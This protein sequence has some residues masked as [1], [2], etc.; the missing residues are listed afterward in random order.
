MKKVFAT[1]LA[2]C[3]VCLAYGAKPEKMSAVLTVLSK[4][5]VI[6]GRISGAEWKNAVQIYGLVKHNSAAMTSRQGT[7]YFGVDKKYFNFAAVTELPPGNIKLLDRVKKRDG[8]VYLDDNVEITI[9]PPHKKFVYQLIVNPQGTLFDRKF[10]VTYGSTTHTD[11]AD[12]TPAA[13]VKSSFANG[14]WTLEGRIPLADMEVSALKSGEVWGILAGRSWQNPGEQTTLKKSM[15]FTNSDE[16]AQFT[17][18]A[19]LP[20]VSFAGLGKNAAKGDFNIVFPVSNPSSVAREVACQVSIVSDSAPRFLDTVITVPAGKTLPAVLN[21]SESNIVVRSISALFK[22]VKSGKVIFERTFTYDP[23][24]KS[25]WNDPAQKRSA[26]LEIG[27]YPYYG[28]IRAR[29]GN[30]AEKISGWQEGTLRLESKEGK[31]VARQNAVKTPYGFE[32]VFNLKPAP[33][34][35][36]IVLTLSD[37]NGKKAEKKRSFVIEKFPWEHNDIGKERIIIPPF[38]A[39]TTPGERSASAT[40]TAYRFGSGF[41]DRVSADGVENIL[42]APVTLSINGKVLTEESFRFTEKSPD[43]VKTDSLLKWEGGSVRILGTMDYDGFYRFSMNVAPDKAQQINSAVLTIPLKREFAAQLHSVCNQM[44]YNDAIYLPKTNGV[45]WQ[46]SQTRRT[47]QLSGN[48]MPYVWVGNLSRGIAWMAQS[49]LNWSLDPRKNAIEIFADADRAELRIHLVNKSTQWSKP[50]ALEQ[51]LQATPVKP[52][53]EYRRR[54]TERVTLPNSWNFCTFAGQATWGSWSDRSFFPL[55]MDYSFVEYLGKGAFSPEGDKRMVSEYFNR[56]SKGFTQEQKNSLKKHL[57]RGVYYAKMAKYKVPYTNARFSHLNWQ[58]YKTYRDEWWCS[59]YRADNADE[60][61]NTPVASYQDAVLYYLQKL[62]RS[63][64]D[65]IYFDNIRDWH[66]TNTVTG[67]A[68]RRADGQIQPYFDIF[69]L[70]EFA[71]RTAV[72]LCQEKKTFPDGR[73]V[74]TMHMTNTNI[75]PVLAFGTIGL[76]LEAEYGSKDYQNRFSEAYLRTCTLGLQSGVIPEILI[77]ITGKQRDFVTRTFLAVTLA[78]DLPFVMNGG[79]LSTEWHRVWGKLYKWGYSTPEVKVLPCWENKSVTTDNPAWR[80]AA[81]RKG[82]EVIAAVCSFGAQTEGTLAL[83][84]AV[85][86][87]DFETGKPLEIKDGKVK[88]NINR[89]DFKLIHFNTK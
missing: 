44:K 84:N 82:G 78:Y 37:A 70:R 27:V 77:V 20:K 81:Y 22:D 69:D 33:G 26:E 21:F 23:T 60:Y 30:P 73:P 40:L 51:A 9:C 38:K 56:H 2:L 5:P 66:N 72:M 65:G 25:R 28:K 83:P 55:G 12:W 52:Q 6:D 74:F 86:A 58:E 47:P 11:Y 31:T 4:S 57:D 80:I 53:P 32:G 61:N 45:V 15:Y 39:I 88:L 68:Y 46:S 49:D 43:R 89:H 3:A 67:P 75:V 17:C 48:F 7:L 87:S 59:E 85:S 36:T 1:L 64:M 8:A 10:P 13:E 19:T 42:A 16:M 18:S 76:D 24:L 71:R 14:V 62:V 63:G 41:F 34:E 54:L 35:Y 50:F 79:G 29:Y